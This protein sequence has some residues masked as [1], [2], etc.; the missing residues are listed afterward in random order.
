MIVVAWILGAVG[1]VANAM[2]YRQKSRK[3]L[4]TAKLIAD[5]IWCS[6]YLCLNALSG[7]LVCGIGVVRESIFLNKEKRW[8]RNKLWLVLFVILNI[9]TGF[10]TRKNI[11]NIL[12][13]IG[14]VTSVI[15][16]WIG[17]PK[18]TKILAYP[19]SLMFLTY[20]VVVLSYFGIL[21]EILLLVSVTAEFIRTSNHSTTVNK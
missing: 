11:L 20:N 12:P 3:M 7:A 18:K 8:A 14:G 6:H 16:F 4:L 15:S 1:V 10:F 5:L 17:D 2:I 9:A 13:C 19:I 21:N